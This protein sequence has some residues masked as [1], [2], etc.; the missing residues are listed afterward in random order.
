MDAG[1]AV[2]DIGMMMMMMDGVYHLVD[3]F[4]Y[5]A[6]LDGI[7]APRLLTHTHTHTHTLSLSLLQKKQNII[8]R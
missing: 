8:Q 1:F 5:P 3:V 4:G 7:Y 6:A 2:I